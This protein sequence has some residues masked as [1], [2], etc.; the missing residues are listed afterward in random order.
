MNGKYGF[1][2]KV[3]I[4]LGLLLVGTG[5]RAGAETIVISHGQITALET[6]LFVLTI[7]DA[8]RPAPLAVQITS[9]TR[10]FKFGQPAVTA[11]LA[12]GDK[13]RGAVDQKANGKCEAVR[14]YVLKSG[15]M[16]LALNK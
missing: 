16:A 7:K 10:L 4:L 1:L 11:G 14:I 6:N 5:L 2:I 3:A 13:V 15:P 8:D 12:V 9:Q